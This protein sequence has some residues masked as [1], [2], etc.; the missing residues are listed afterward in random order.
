MGLHFAMFA[1]SPS[2]TSV[3]VEC[4]VQFGDDVAP[5]SVA[6]QNDTFVAV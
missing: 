2:M 3:A 5:S 6:I 4:E 1:S